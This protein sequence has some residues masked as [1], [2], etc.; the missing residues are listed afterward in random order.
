M[1]NREFSAPPPK[2]RVL[3][4]DDIAK[5]LQVVG[6]MLRNEGYQ[7]MPATNGA[8]ALERALALPPDLILLDLMMPEMD[9]Y[10]VC[11]WVRS[12][13][14]T[15]A[16]PVVM[17]SGKADAESVAR[18]LEFGADEYLAKPITPSALTSQLRAVLERT[19]ARVAASA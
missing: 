4:V 8:Q 11:Q 3:V 17:L 16:L 5:N 14:A 13:P 6:T 15:T 18:G 10:E 2:S 19:A 9:G 1:S 12:N 7:V